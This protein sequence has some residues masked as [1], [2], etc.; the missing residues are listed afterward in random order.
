MIGLNQAIQ[1][2]LK[3]KLKQNLKIAQKDARN[4]SNRHFIYSRYF[5]KYKE[6]EK[7]E[8]GGGGEGGGGGGGGGSGGEMEVDSHNMRELKSLADQMLQKRDH[9]ARHV[10][11][12]WSEPTEAKKMQEVADIAHQLHRDYLRMS[13]STPLGEISPMPD[14]VIDNSAP[15]ENIR[16]ALQ[17]QRL[18]TEKTEAEKALVGAAKDIAEQAHARADFNT[19]NENLETARAA[20]LEWSHDNLAALC[21]EDIN[22]TT[23]RY[24]DD[25]KG[26]PIKGGPVPDIALTTSQINRLGKRAEELVKLSSSQALVPFLS[27]PIETNVAVAAYR[28]HL[29]AV[30]ETPGIYRLV[31]LS[32][33]ILWSR[34]ILVN[35]GIPNASGKGMRRLASLRSMGDEEHLKLLISCRGIVGVAHNGYHTLNRASAHKHGRMIG[36]CMIEIR[37]S[38]DLDG[39]KEDFDTWETRSDWQQFRGKDLADWEIYRFAKTHNQGGIPPS[40]PARPSQALVARQR[41]RGGGSGPDGELMHYSD[42]EDE[43]GTSDKEYSDD[44]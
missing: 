35:E 26:E 40:P 24:I 32:K 44:D 13:Y 27:A 42:T 37:W 11:T 30:V 15:Q 38:G 23:Y 36:P 39:K 19:A 8:W 18:V 10:W 7:G 41:V 4:F 1:K 17:I 6:E 16:R 34:E 3:G 25:G 29:L 2:A 14:N 43:E 12:L 5:P 28:N 22:Q 33:Q 9:A 21:P 20:F 31:L